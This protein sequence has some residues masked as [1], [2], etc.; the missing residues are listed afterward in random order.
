[1]VG[2]VDGNEVV[3]F[4]VGCCDGLEDSGENEGDLDG[5]DVVGVFDGI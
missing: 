5:R 4:W 1:M 2:L 3:G